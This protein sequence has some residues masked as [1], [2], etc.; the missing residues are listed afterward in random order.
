MRLQLQDTSF[1]TDYGRG[2][3]GWHA[4]RIENPYGDGV[5][6]TY[7][8]ST[9]Y[10]WVPYQ[11]TIPSIGSSPSTRTITINM[12]GSPS[13]VSTIKVPTFN[14]A[15]SSTY[16]LTTAQHGSG[17]MRPYPH[18]T[19]ST[20]T[21]YYLD[22]IDLPMTGYSYVFSYN[23]TGTLANKNVNGTMSRQVIP[24]GASVDYEYGT[25]TWYHANALGR[26]TNCGY[27]LVSYPTGRPVLKTGPG[28]EPTLT[29]PGT[30]CGAA[31]RAAG[32][33]KRSVTYTTLTTPETAV[34]KYYQYDYPQ[35][36]SGSGTSAESQ[37]LVLSPTD[38]NGSQHSA[39]YLFSVSTPQAI[40]GPLVG[41]L[42]RTAVY[43]GDQSSGTSSIPDTSSARRVERYTYETDSF[44]QNPVSP[45]SEAFEANRRVIQK[46]AIY[47]G[48][49]STSP[50][51]GKYHQI[52]YDFDPTAGRYSRETHSGTIGGDA[53]EI[54]TT[55][56]P[57]TT[58]WK[59]DK[60]QTVHLRTAVGAATDFST[61]ANQFDA[62]GFVNSTTVTDGNGYG[63]L[64]HGSPR[65]AT[66]GFPTSETF[67]HGSST[68][69]QNLTFK[70]ATLETAKW[71]GFSWNAV[72][73][74]QIDPYTGLVKM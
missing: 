28:V 5:D 18:P 10:A 42:L 31:D 51:S 56:T 52:D 40:S 44:D 7:Q 66:H 16:T 46:L 38:D 12:S 32:I 9:S 27:P 67:T 73:N 30:D 68:F 2:R 60:A 26:P 15:S 72:N 65:D 45:S 70:A 59:L 33:V 69:T 61:V 4:T 57:D 1:Q 24:T 64:V 63:T 14:S 19:T 53:R 37:T 43:H 47:K 58:N 23:T 55:W 39:T 29:H 6:I 25:W 34:T 62:K 48:I 3:N 11:I 74:S 49:G 20:A 41:G 13:R 22:R 35:G 17:L 50:P 8:T 21:Q 54:E 71:S 36:E